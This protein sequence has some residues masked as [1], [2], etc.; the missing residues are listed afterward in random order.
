VTGPDARSLS[1]SCRRRTRTPGTPASQRRRWRACCPAGT[2]CD[3]LRWARGKL[4]QCARRLPID[5]A[6]PLG[7][8]A[9]LKDRGH[10][11]PQRAGEVLLTHQ[12]GAVTGVDE[13]D[14]AARPRPVGRRK[15]RTRS[16]RLS[17]RPAPVRL[18]V[19]SAR[20]GMLPSQ[21]IS[22]TTTLT[23]TSV[24]R[25]RTLGLLVWPVR[26]KARAG[27]AHHAPTGRRD[28]PGDTASGVGFRG[29]HAG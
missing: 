23:L 9:R 28:L 6:A 1:S 27:Q 10:Q 16:I 13:V 5:L 2:R 8:V 22:V 29:A 11:V 14:R 26:R 19:S 24:P 25:I 18:Q 17:Q 12:D 21:L 4:A 15:A 3:Q 20:R 7:R